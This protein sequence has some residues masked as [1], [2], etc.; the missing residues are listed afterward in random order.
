MDA[1]NLLLDSLDERETTYGEKL[2]RC[3]DDFSGGAVHDVRTS[4]RRLLAVLDIAAF[5][6]SGS[7][8]AK[9]SHRLKDQLD[10]FDDLRDIQMLLDKISEGIGA[11]P[12]LELFQ[13][14]LKKRE[15]R[16]QLAGK[17]H[18][19]DIK[20]GSVNKSFMKVHESVEDLSEQEVQSQLPQAVDEAY[21]RVMQRYGE[22]DPAQLVSIHH[23][24]IAFKK[25][26]YMMEIIHPCLSDFPELQLRRMH[27]YQTQM[28]CIHD[29][30]VFLETLAKF[31]REHHSY[32]PQPV[33]RFYERILA[34]SLS[35][36]LENKDQVLTF[37]RANPLVAFPWKV[38][39]TEKEK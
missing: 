30:Q 11:L 7:R 33:R 14:H 21:L 4:I 25:F 39:R 35:A 27:A 36:Y 22:L 20:P 23:L 28:G 29:M 13:E 19:R 31:A 38:D 18:A 34:E 10:G 37:W 32:D 5:M 24:R 6:I 9:L 12:E 1:K 26:R 2:K 16:K 15:K 8:V 3:R 17:K